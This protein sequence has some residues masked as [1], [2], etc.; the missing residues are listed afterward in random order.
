MHIIYFYQTFTG[1]SKLLSNAK[2]VDVINVSAIHFGRNVQSGNPDIRLNDHS[3][4]NPIFYSMW[5]ET[6][7]AS[8]LGVKIHLMIGGAGSAYTK[9][10]SDFETYY[11]LLVKT[12]QDRP[13]ITG[14]DLDVEEP[15]GYFEI[16]KLIARIRKDF[17]TDF[18]I[19]MSPVQSALERNVGPWGG[20][21]YKDLFQSPEGK[22][23]AWFHVQACS[24]YYFTSYQAMINNGYPANKIVY[25]TV[26]K[27]FSHGN[28]RNCVREIRKI[29]QTYGDMGGVYNW[30][31]FDAPPG[32]E[33]MDWAELMYYLVKN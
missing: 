31:Y 28:F 24:D 26:S 15:I 25:G 19:T 11:A 3:P 23:I 8:E 4:D 14:V 2:Y 29:K 9:L 10:F 18:L 1:L 5:E 16:R 32:P 22:E 30:E 6:K 21:S 33:P 20:F 27:D 7:K 13:W 12:I 17:G